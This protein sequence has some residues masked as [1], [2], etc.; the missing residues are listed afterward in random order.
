M[1]EIT[2]YGAP[3]CPDCKRSKQFLAQH[4][5]AY[6]W[7][8]VDQDPEA[9]SFVESLQKGGRTIPTVVFGEGDYLLEPSDEELAR[10]LGLALRAERSFYDVAMVGGGPAALAAAIYEIGRAHV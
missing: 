7:V 9:L 10:K 3:W 5:V 8:D 4:R 6:R 2:V 1:S